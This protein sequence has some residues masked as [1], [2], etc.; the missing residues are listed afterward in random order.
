MPAQDVGNHIVG[1]DIIQVRVEPRVRRAWHTGETWAFNYSA[2]N[3]RPDLLIGTPPHFQVLSLAASPKENVRL[4]P[5]IPTHIW[6]C[7]AIGSGVVDNLGHEVGEF[8]PIA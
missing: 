2:G 7:H 6:T 1:P 3:S 5:D 8:C 4:I